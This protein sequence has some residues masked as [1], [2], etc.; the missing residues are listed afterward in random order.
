[1]YLI[2]WNKEHL[3]FHLQYK[4]SGKFANRKYEKLSY[5]KNQKICDPI[6][7]TLWKC[8]PVIDE[9]IE[10]YSKCSKR[11]TCGTPLLVDELSFDGGLKKA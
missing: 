2:S 9:N 3:T 4:H 11:E 8:D 6:L 5:P 10:H 7:V 1:M